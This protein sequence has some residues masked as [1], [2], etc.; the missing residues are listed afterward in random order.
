MKVNRWILSLLMG[1]PNSALLR[2]HLFSHVT[3]PTNHVA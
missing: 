2:D 1:C 3:D